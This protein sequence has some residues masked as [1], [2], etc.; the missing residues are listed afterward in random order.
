[1]DGLLIIV[2]IIVIPLVIILVAYSAEKQRQPQAPLG[3]FAKLHHLTLTSTDDGPRLFGPLGGRSL[4]I[5][6]FIPNPRI[7]RHHIRI[8]LSINAPSHVYLH[9][10]GRTF[11]FHAWDPEAENT[12]SLDLLFEGESHPSDFVTTLSTA[13]PLLGY[14]LGRAVK[15]IGNY[16]YPLLEVKA[17]Q[18]TL[19]HN[20][21]E[22]STAE[23]ETVITALDRFASAIEQTA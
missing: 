10:K 13:D 20:R 15:Q 14:K 12:P 21:P 6:T 8:L 18:V 2:T 11:L 23:L 5:E 7:R 4:T 22:L 19:T 3:E 16:P 1:V 9:V 17:G